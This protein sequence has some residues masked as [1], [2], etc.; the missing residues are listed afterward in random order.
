MIDGPLT[1]SP[2][3]GDEAT[4]ISGFCG[5]RIA[6]TRAGGSLPA[7]RSTRAISAASSFISSPRGVRRDHHPASVALDVNAREPQRAARRLALVFD[8]RVAQ[9]G[10]DRGVA[11]DADAE[12]VLLHV[13]EELARARLQIAEV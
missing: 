6:V 1:L 2:S 5:R 3:E 10:G 11:V 8:L 13:G 9:P 12:V 4:V 7:C